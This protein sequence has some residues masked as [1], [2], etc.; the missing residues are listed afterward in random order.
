MNN[1]ISQ[2]LYSNEALDSKL[3]KFTFLNYQEFLKKNNIVIKYYFKN[4]NE[5]EKWLIIFKQ[6]IYIP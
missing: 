6:T 4:L 5:M 1:I 3:N 2:D